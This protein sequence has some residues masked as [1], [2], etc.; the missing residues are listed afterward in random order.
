MHQDRE[1][2]LLSPPV[3][4]RELGFSSWLIV[5]VLLVVV[6]LMWVLSLAHTIVMPLLAA[7]VI[8][9]VAAPLVARLARHMPRGLATVLLILGLIAVGALIVVIVVGGVS[10]QGDSISKHLSGAESEV[11]GWLNDIG[12]DKSKAESA[13]KDAGSSSTSS[14]E[15][16]LHGVAKGIEGLAG[17]AFFLA[18]TLLSLVFLLK[19]GPQIRAWGEAH[20]GLPRE[21]A[22]TIAERV[23]QSLRGYFLGV[24]I[25]AAFNGIVVGG[26]ALVIGIPL[27]GTIAVVTFV[28]AYVPYLGAWLAGAFAVLLALGSSG[29]DA[30]AAMIVVQILANGV[31]QQLVQPFAMGAALGIHPLAV[32][33][34]TIAGGAIFGAAGLILAAPMVS[35]VTRI[36]ADV[37]SAKARDAG[38]GADAPAAGGAAAAP[39]Q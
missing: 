32:L 7:G 19:D 20:L 36:S 13:A 34:V 5:G 27:A 2:T 8:S 35:A 28:G 11:S 26:A 15:T 4:L 29:S 10:S 18:L 30:A 14:V 16:L 22:H 31:L 25:V 38:A 39:A 17:L 21:L 23:L 12:V 33:V 6:G 37:A 3:W 1:R 9:A 24:T